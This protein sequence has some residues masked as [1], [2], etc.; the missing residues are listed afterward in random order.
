MQQNN[1]STKCRYSI[2]I[3]F[4]ICF[5]SFFAK[6]Q[7]TD[8]V[9]I[10]INNILAPL[11]KTLIPTGIL[12]ENSYP[13]LNLSTYDGQL[14]AEN[15]IDFSQWRL[16]YNQALSG[17]YVAPIGLPSIAQLNIDY[18]AASNSGANNV[19]SL[20]L[21]NYASINPTA[22]TAGLMSVVNGQLYDGIAAKAGS[23][24]RP[25]PNAYLINRLFI[26]AANNNSAKNGVLKLL[27]KPNLFYTNTGLTVS[28][29]EVDFDNGIGFVPA[30]FNTIITGQYTTIGNKQLTYRITFSDGSIAQ[31]Y[32]TVYVDYIPSPTNIS[33][34]TGAVTINGADLPDTVLNSPT[35]AHSGVDLFIRR[36][37][38]NQGSNTNPQFRKPLIIVE[39]LDLSS[40]TTLLGNGYNYNKF[41]KEII[42]D[43]TRFISGTNPINT[44]EN[45]L[46]SVAGYDLIFVNWHNG[47]DDILRNVLA[48]R[49]V[50]NYVNER[51]LPGAEQN[52]IIGISMG[53]IVSRYCLAEMV[54][55]GGTGD[56]DHQTRLLITHDSPHRGANIPLALQH[57]LQG[58]RKQTIKA[59]IGT[60]SIRLDEL[61]PKLMDINT[62]LN[63]GAARD[64]LV[65]RVIDDN[66]TV[67]YNTFLDGPYRTMINFDG[68]SITQP[69]R[70]VATSNGSQ[71]GEVV[72]APNSVLASLNANGI[73]NLFGLALWTEGRTYLDMRRLPEMGQTSRILDFALELKIKFLVFNKLKIAMKIQQN[74]SGN[75]LPLDGAAG[76]TRRLGA[77]IPATTLSSITPASGSSNWL[78]FGY[79]YNYSTPYV[80]PTFTFITTASALD[81]VNLNAINIPYNV[82][83]TGLNGSR[84]ANYI[85]QE[86]I[87]LLAPTGIINNVNHTDFYARTCRWLFNEME[88]LTQPINC[89]DF[90]S[91]TIAG[92]AIIGSRIVC[93]TALY[94]VIN[95]PAGYIATWSLPFGS[96]ST[97]VLSTNGPGNTGS[98]CTVTNMH[99]Y[100][101]NTNLTVTFSK[102][103]C[104]S[105]G[106][107]TKFIS[108]DA[109]YQSP[110][111]QGYSFVQDACL[112]Y[113]VN[114]PAESGIINPSN[115]PVFIHAGCMVTVNIGDLD[116]IGKT[117]TYTG[118]VVPLYWNFNGTLLRFAM[119]SG[120]GGIP[121]TFKIS[122]QGAC[123]DRTLLFFVYSNN[124]RISYA[125]TPNPVSD[126]LT[127]KV[128]ED[129][130]VP[131][132]VT[133]TTKEYI[134]KIAEFNTMS[135]LRQ[136]KINKTG[137]EFQID[138]SGLKTGYYAVEIKNGED[139]QVLKVY[140]L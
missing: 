63:S 45:Y 102:P 2:T 58:L 76:G 10:A 49:K 67:A 48:L 128:T 38:S 19:V 11:N 30:T 129:N 32:N 66:G 5:F 75:L 51:K 18:N 111:T 29:I 28:S 31:C 60:Y 78:I 112:A 25:K 15:T 12:A 123:F 87:S 126:I 52:V 50:I 115:G 138:M 101:L 82:S 124:G 105:I 79:T 36:S 73:A 22:I 97:L 39:G 44:F 114:H 59:F 131:N 90:C 96:G 125:A 55:A 139:V 135:F 27:F 26:S 134:V 132:T 136:Q 40:A 33:S 17:A 74:T 104:T 119:P 14:T 70:F 64:Q 84:A 3:I 20:S 88:N 130:T 56:N 71:C 116:L 23:P 107:V 77:Y 89:D 8:S 94:N 140:K 47:V 4:F 53:G 80:A 113:N 13:L 92:A 127:V 122:G 46:D 68:T 133:P 57:L 95:I 72:A 7:T 41:F 108:T 83:Q 16:L 91:A 6:A 121:V 110:S 43:Q 1:K 98:Q 100:G 9:R 118:S 69:Y 54:K 81:V 93:N 24:I 62:T 137:S 86:Q 34:Y 21:I 109:D 117:I 99:Y 103:N 35:N 37:V 85:A 120:S 42:A 61:I 106:T 65:V